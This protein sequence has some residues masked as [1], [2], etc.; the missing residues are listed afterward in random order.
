M[1]ADY[2]VPQILH[3]L[4]MLRYT[5]ELE[6]LLR[7]G[8]YIPH[9]SPEEL[10]LRAASILAVEHV[11]EKINYPNVSSVL[12]DFFLWDMAK[13]VEAGEEVI[14]GLDTQAAL[15]AHH[16]RCIWY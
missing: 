14:E 13:R 9:G 2:R 11:R 4:N 3:H 7:N 8:A 10:A 6:L 15:P 16:T 12:I 1:F 5:P